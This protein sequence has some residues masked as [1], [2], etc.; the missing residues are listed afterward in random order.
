MKP[1]IQYEAYSKAINIEARSM[2]DI[3]SKHIIPSVLQ[4]TTALA[5]SINQ[6]R[7]A[8][9]EANISVQIELLKDCSSLLAATKAALKALTE[10]TEQAAATAEGRERAVCQGSKG[11]GRRYHHELQIPGGRRNGRIQLRP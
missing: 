5:T 3:A 9:A 1:L 4:Y 7:S 10:V 6:I 8:C 11:L 2:I